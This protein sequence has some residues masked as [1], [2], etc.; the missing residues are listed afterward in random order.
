MEV[1]V[2]LPADF[3]TSLESSIKAVAENVFLDIKQKASYPEYMDTNTVCKYLGIS[4][5]TLNTRLKPSGLPIIVIDGSIVRFSK[6]AV[7]EFMRKIT[8]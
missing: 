8:I 7:D 3:E 2:D 4:R 6:T 5:T 1:K